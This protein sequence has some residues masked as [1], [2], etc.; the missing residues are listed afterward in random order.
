MIATIILLPFR[1]IKIIL[2]TFASLVRL[3]V[4]LGAGVVRFVFSHLLGT[5]IG[6]ALGLLLGRRRV[7]IRWPRRYRSRTDS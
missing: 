1:L 5:L 7:G 2:T 4:A 3:V 6:A